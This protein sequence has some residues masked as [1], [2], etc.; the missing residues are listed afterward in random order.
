MPIDPRDILRAIGYTDELI[1]QVE[2]NAGAIHSLEL[3][4]KGSR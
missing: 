2:D 1:A 3:T 4:L